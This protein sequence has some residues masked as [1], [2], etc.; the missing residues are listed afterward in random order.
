[1][2]ASPDSLVVKPE[3]LLRAALTPEQEM[4]RDLERF[5][6]LADALEWRAG[7]N[8]SLRA[9]LFN[10][11]LAQLEKEKTGGAR[12]VNEPAPPRARGH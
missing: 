11:A 10:L 7:F 12:G 8:S 4:R 5:R 1:M 3:F 2:S 9:R 6:I